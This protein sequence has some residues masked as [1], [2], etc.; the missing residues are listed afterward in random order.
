[1]TFISAKSK[2]EA[3][4]TLVDCCKI[5]KVFGGYAGFKT[6][7]EYKTWKSQK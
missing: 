4:E 6:V 3:K 5:V 7:D 1:M 2:K